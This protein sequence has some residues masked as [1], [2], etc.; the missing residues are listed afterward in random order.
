MVNDAEEK[1][2]LLLAGS[3]HAEGTW[4]GLSQTRFRASCLDDHWGINGMGEMK[5]AVILRENNLV[6]LESRQRTLSIL[7]TFVAFFCLSAASTMSAQS[8]HASKPATAEAIQ[9]VSRSGNDSNDGR[10]WASAKL[11]IY[12]AWTALPPGGAGCASSCGGTIYFTN[13]I[14]FG[15]P[16]PGQGLW[17]AGASDPNFSS[18]PPGWVKE[19]AVRMV[20]S[21][22]G[23]WGSQSAV[24]QCLVTGESGTVP[25]LRISGSSDPME[26]DGMK[27]LSGSGSV[28]A[29]DSNGVFENHAGVSN[30]TFRDCAF[31]FNNAIATNGPGLRIGPNSFENYFYNTIFDGNPNAIA[32]SEPRQALVLDPGSKLNNDSGT[33]FVFHSHANTGGIEI[34]PDGEGSAGAVIDG[35]V[36]EGQTDHKG[37][38]WITET[39]EDTWFNL[40]DI[41]AADTALSTDPTIEVDGNGP[42]DA[43]V[44]V[45]VTSNTVGPM[46]LVG[47]NPSAIQSIVV[48]PDKQ[49]Q[50]GFLGGHLLGQTDAA[51]R[52][53]SPAAVR[54]A[55]LAATS[56][57]NWTT[58]GGGVI[59]TGIT[60]PDGT[61][62]A[63]ECSSTSGAANCYFYNANQTFAVGD[64]IVVGVWAQAQ[65]AV[66]F[67]SKQVISIST[68]SCSFCTFV[69]ISGQ[70]GSN[71][72]FVPAYI[73]GD[74][75]HGAPSAEW[76]WYW[77]V[78]KV[79]RTKGRGTQTQFIAN[80]QPGYPANYYA[81]MF[82]HIAANTIGDNEATELG[83]NLQSYGSSCAVGTVCGLPGQTQA[84]ARLGQMAANQF[85]GTTKLS[86]GTV[87]V[88]FPT[89]YRNAPICVANDTTSTSNGIK[90]TSATTNVTF[91][92]TGTDSIAYICVGNPN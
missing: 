91:S 72:G 61:T 71:S 40:K 70:G 58:G 28:L 82:L 12:A 17:I 52:G 66:G 13:N 44:V 29:M 19:A 7:I 1:P 64:I 9:F 32:A 18:L 60:A 20:C 16:V 67:N 23:Q 22:P 59:T 5:L 63:G 3:V 36:C 80:V 2:R 33:V 84:P 21:G 55:N 42:P 14:T 8:N 37:C 79:T 39:D 54:F 15:G 38:V 75:S 56:P 69:D 34:V 10:S 6:C 27:F 24:P 53:F 68:P 57:S 62:G 90:P 47:Q 87:T 74:G 77:K 86:N 81:P 41:W 26:F 48:S 46:D 35:V 73:L 50:V 4:S 31:G 83:L 25:A 51:R 76:E 92:G 49:H 11:T 43:V 78:L 85:A 88:S 30:K 89:P 45:G 65:N